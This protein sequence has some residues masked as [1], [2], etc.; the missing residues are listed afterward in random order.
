V[1]RN[2][3]SG[4]IFLR[5]PLSF[6]IPKQKTP[7]RA[8]TCVQFTFE[9]TCTLSSHRTSPHITFICFFFFRG[10][11][12]R[13]GLDVRVGSFG[14]SATVDGHGAKFTKKKKR[15]KRN[16]K[17]SLSSNLKCKR[18]LNGNIPSDPTDE[19]VSTYINAFLR[20]RANAKG[21]IREMFDANC[22]TVG[23]GVCSDIFDL[24]TAN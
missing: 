6:V 4:H 19:L 13:L 12:I 7:L 22:T 14:V 18:L 24:E 8:H 23:L 5:T 11:S 20:D 3:C 17:K 10:S 9:T 2:I 15:K 16:P 21:C 1:R